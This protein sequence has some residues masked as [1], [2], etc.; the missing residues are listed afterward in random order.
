MCLIFESSDDKQRKW[1]SFHLSLV[2]VFL[3]IVKLGVL[4]Q[5][6]GRQFDEFASIF[7]LEILSKCN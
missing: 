4:S 6:G 2:V 1:S 7:M 3:V 5:V